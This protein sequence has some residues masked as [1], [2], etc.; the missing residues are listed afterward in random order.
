MSLNVTPANFPGLA[1]QIGFGAS[2]LQGAL[3]AYAAACVPAPPG[4]D[5]VSAM[6]PEVLSRL[7]KGFFVTTDHGAVLQSEASVTMP[8]V[9]TSYSGGDIINGADVRSRATLF[10]E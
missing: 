3:D 5:D 1:S 2:D 6:L 7:G 8:Q 10:T 4:A 9:G